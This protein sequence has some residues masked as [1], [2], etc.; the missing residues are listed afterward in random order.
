MPVSTTARNRLVL[1]AL[2]GFA[3]TMLMVP[4]WFVQ[5]KGKPATDRTA[6]LTGSQIQRGPYMN[7]GSRDIGV[8]PNWDLSTGTWHGNDKK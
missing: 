2:G 6:A 4:R 3:G 5:A 7:S 1:V 8:D